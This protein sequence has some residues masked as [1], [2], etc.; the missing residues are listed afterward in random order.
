MN[1]VKRSMSRALSFSVVKMI[2]IAITC[3]VVSETVASTP[4]MPVPGT[5]SSGIAL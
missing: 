2:A 1:V 3:A 5:V 4:P